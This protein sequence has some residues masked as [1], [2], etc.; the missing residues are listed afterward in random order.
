[1][2]IKQLL[3]KIIILILIIACKE[4]PKNTS[5]KTLNYQSEKS[6]Q[7]SI[8]EIKNTSDTINRQICT[9]IADTII[10]DVIIKNPDTNDFWT[11]ECLKYVK[12]DTFIDFIFNKIYKKEIIAFDIFTGQPLNIKEI[13]KIEKESDFNKKNIAKL[14]FTEKWLFDPY[15][16]TFKKE[17]ISISLGYEVKDKHGKIRG[18]KP[19]FKIKFNN[20]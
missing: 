9:I 7:K 10:Y 19:L 20:Y 15:K 5:Y 6:E 12:L 2:K 18:Y 4:N 1:M 3:T 11:K 13:K 16:N 14:Q 17:I 8:S